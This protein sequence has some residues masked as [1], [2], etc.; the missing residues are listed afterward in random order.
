MLATGLTFLSPLGAI[1][2]LAALAAL[3]ATALGCR[4]ADAVRRLLRLDARSHRRGRLALVAGLVVVVA[5]AGAQPALTHASRLQVRRDV[6]ALFVV[7]TSRS[8]AAAS[9]AGAPSRLDRATAA[10]IRLRAAIPIVASGV[11]TLTDRVLPNLLPVADRT[12]FDGVM[13]LGVAIESPP[14]K[15]SAVR[16]TA[17]DALGAIPGGGFFA[18]GTRTRLVVVLTDGESVPVQTDELVRAFGSVPGFHVV[19]VRFWRPGEAIFDAGGRREAAYRPDSS[20]G[21]LVD[22]LVAALGGSAYGE[23]ELAAAGR[24][25]SELAGNGPAA[26]VPGTSTTREALAPPLIAVSILLLAVL[27]AGMSPAWSARLRLQWR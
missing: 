6:Q 21:A 7:D 13:A 24:R 10:A 12:G 20:S 5:L 19:V 16:A 27:L 9:S 2:G 1:A 26:A 17:F 25:L 4:R 15:D 18:P 22:G 23:T 14:P 8:M 11:A 3:A